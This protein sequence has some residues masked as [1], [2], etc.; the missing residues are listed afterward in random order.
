MDDATGEV[1][2]KEISVAALRKAVDLFS[3][4]EERG[5]ALRKMLHSLIRARIHF[6]T[7]DWTSLT[8]TSLHGLK[9]MHEQYCGSLANNGVVG[10]TTDN[11]DNDDNDDNGDNNDDNDDNDDNNN[12]D[13]NND[14]DDDNDNDDD[15]D[16]NDNDNNNDDNDND[17]NN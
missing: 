6:Q 15:N 4:H 17:N 2:R 10:P 3:L 16:D 11:D 14:D 7:G 8:T 12:D 9:K 5:G 13:D 1:D